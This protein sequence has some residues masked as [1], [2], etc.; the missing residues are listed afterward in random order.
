MQVFNHKFCVAQRFNYLVEFDRPQKQLKNGTKTNVE[1]DMAT[2]WYNN[3]LYK[4][5]ITHYAWHK[6]LTIRSNSTDL[7]NSLKMAQKANVEPDMATYWYNS[8]LCKFLITNYVWHNDLTTRSNS[9]GLK[10]SLK[11]AQKQMLSLIWLPTGAMVCCTGFKS[12]IRLGTTN[13][14]PGQ[15]QPA[16]KI[17]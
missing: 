5:L 3:M 17:A 16:S 1:P 15:I 11:M 10:N 4:F 12:D 6:D 9:T 14:L 2:Y 13:Y 7:K 8:M